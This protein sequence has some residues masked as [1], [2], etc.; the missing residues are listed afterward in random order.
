MLV[1]LNPVEASQ[2]YDLDFKN[3]DEAITW[4]AASLSVS[5]CRTLRRSGI[6]EVE[7][8]KEWMSLCGSIQNFLIIRDDYK[9]S[10][11]SLR[12]LLNSVATVDNLLELLRDGVRIHEIIDWYAPGIESINP[13]ELRRWIKNGFDSSTATRGHELGINPEVADRLRERNF[14]FEDWTSWIA[15]C[16]SPEFVEAAI[17][18]L[19]SREL[20]EEWLHGNFPVSRM[21]ACA[22]YSLSLSTFKKWNEIGLSDEALI[23]KWEDSGV[24]PF[25][26][27]VWFQGGVHDV[28]VAKRWGEYGFVASDALK[29]ISL[30]FLLPSPVRQV[31]DAQFDGKGTRAI[32]ALESLVSRGLTAEVLTRWISAGWRGAGIDSIERVWAS[33][34]LLSQWN[35]SEIDM[36]EWWDWIPV[37]SGKAAVAKAWSDA[38]YSTSEI[39][40]LKGKYSISVDDV[41]LW[42][43]EGLGARDLVRAHQGGMQKPSQW[44]S[45]LATQNEKKRS[46]VLGTTRPSSRY[47][48]WLLDIRNSVPTASI[49]RRGFTPLL[50]SAFN[51]GFV[52]N[53]DPVIK[54]KASGDWYDEIAGRVMLLKGLL[55]KVPQWP[56]WYV[57]EQFVV[58][59]AEADGKVLAWVGLG[60][61]GRVVLFDAN[62]LEPSTKLETPYDLLV[63]GLA[64][65]WFLDSSLLLDRQIETISLINDVYRPTKNFSSFVSRQRRFSD[66]IPRACEVSGHLRLLPR[67]MNPSHSQR[68]MAP[69][70]LQAR[71]ESQHT[72]VRPHS[73]NGEALKLE[74]AEHL[75]RYSAT[76][77]A[78]ALIGVV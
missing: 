8:A 22:N 69:S 49:Y 58:G 75:S 42:T 10:L 18:N 9:I 12:K 3:V 24:P 33:D 23:Q 64:M 51:K 39:Q 17:Q 72:Y 73:R 4:R 67:Y 27:K 19:G 7:D 77:A 54:L 76:A 70:Y 71:M 43:K 16:G 34:K 20:I 11:E 44:K 65:S 45:F 28:G 55:R 1:G 37:T 13:D 78:V 14:T 47:D 74:L 61:V 41:L 66:E 38:H 30:G 63:H 2:W 53:R 32:S 48:N 35:N 36:S 21:V 68:A 60:N 6:E 5:T 46:P 50:E 40:E 56:T 59:C 29:A 57:S 15:N 26:A 25:V 62:T 31:A 52:L